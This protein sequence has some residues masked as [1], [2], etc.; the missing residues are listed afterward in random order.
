MIA[1]VES[2]AYEDSEGR[3]RAIYDEA[4]VHDGLVHNLYRAHSLRPETIDGSDRLYK[5]ALHCA[6]NI[7]APWLGELIATYTAA[8]TRCHYAFVNHGAN[9]RQ[10]LGD[11]ERADQ[12]LEALPTAPP[13]PELDDKTLAMLEYVRKLTLEPGEMNARDVHALRALGLTDGEIVEV[14]QICASFNYYARTLNG[15]GVELDSWTGLYD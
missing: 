3:L 10:H 8:L 2:I 6:D 15:L 9:F 14:N 5:A 1:W 13:F 11:P 4:S 12:I 7:L